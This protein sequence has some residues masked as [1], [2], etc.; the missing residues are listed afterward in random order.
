MNKI[1]TFTNVALASIGIFS[2]VRTVP[3]LLMPVAIIQ[4][5]RSLA[6]VGTAITT[7]CAAG[8]W[9]VALFYVFAVRREQLSRKIVGTDALPEPDSQIQW[10]PVAFRLICIA[11]GLYCLHTVAWRMVSDLSIYFFHKADA[12]YVEMPLRADQILSWLMML[13]IAVYLLC[14][15]PHFVRWHVKKTLQL[16]KHQAKPQD[17]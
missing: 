9:L 14:G 7:V 3:Y 8:L 17:K 10:L 12:R 13:A 1:H 4:G 6:S 16:C 5:E 2:A 11:A 15:A